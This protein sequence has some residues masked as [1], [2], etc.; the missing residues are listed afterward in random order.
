[1]E[2]G[3]NLCG[4][5]TPGIRQW[6]YD[7][8]ETIQTAAHIGQLLHHSDRIVVL[9]N[10]MIP[11]L[12]YYGLVS[13]HVWWDIKRIRMIQEGFEFPP[14]EE[15]FPRRFESVQPEYFIAW[16]DNRLPYHPELAQYL[17]RRYPVLEKGD[18]YVIY[19]LRSVPDAHSI[20]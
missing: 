2:Y 20:R 13:V 10:T 1:L 19:D 12:N 16:P 4:A 7:H 11:I 6:G 15:E 5:N 3:L 17:E 14:V 8:S 18:G 9:G